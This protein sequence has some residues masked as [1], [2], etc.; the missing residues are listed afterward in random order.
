MHVIIKH[1]GEEVG[2]VFTNRSLS[3]DETL[4]FAGIDIN[5]IKGGDPVWNIDAF[6]FDY[7]SDREYAAMLMGS[8]TSDAKA[9]AA[10][11]NG[12]RGGRPKKQT[13]S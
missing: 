13:D 6:E 4:R 9:A 12:K 11:E 10:R 1:E 5:E 7:L 2:R 3:T 8:A